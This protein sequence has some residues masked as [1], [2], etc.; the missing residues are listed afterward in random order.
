MRPPI[1]LVLDLTPLSATSSLRG[2]GRYVRGLVQGLYELDPEQR[3][4]FRFE[5]LCADR[6]LVR[7]SRVEDLRAVCAAAPPR[8]VRSADARRNALV[9]LASPRFF[10]APTRFLHLTDPKGMPLGRRGDY[11]LTCHDLISLAL[12]E[13]YLPHLPG[14]PA[15]VQRLERARYGRARRILAVSHATKRDLSRFLGIAD[16]RIDV[17][18][19]G[20]DHQRFAPEPRHDDELARVHAAIGS[21]EPYVLYMGA[22]DAR[23]DLDT[24]LVAFAE[25]GLARVAR[26]V[27]AGRLPPTRQQGLKQRALS[28]GIADRVALLG[29]VDEELVPALYRQSRV[30]VFPSLYE[31]FGLPVLEALAAGAPTITSPGSALDEVAGDAAEIVACRDVPALSGALK[32]L[33][34]DDAART[35]LRERGFTRARQFT[36]RACAEATLQ[37]WRRAFA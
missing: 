22:G 35:R 29:Y 6:Q 33:F 34:F 18:W 21:G 17:V 19:H 7:L 24:L 8:L 2:I 32:G 37:F 3:S 14:W 4:D 30:H 15:L 31:G 10:G 20:V 9:S 12:P 27:I 13:L 28:L 26:L 5:G 16:D 36:W 11:S 23:K 1:P 25:A